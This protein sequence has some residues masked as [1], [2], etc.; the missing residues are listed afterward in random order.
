MRPEIVGEAVQEIARDPEIAHAMF[1]IL[2]IG[3]ITE[4]K[5]EITLVPKNAT[6]L[7]ET[8]GGHAK[9]V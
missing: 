4:G 3:K 1:E 8:M 5:A 2:E 9:V 6:L 7:I